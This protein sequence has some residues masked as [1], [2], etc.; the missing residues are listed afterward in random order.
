MIAAAG[1][2]G[3]VGIKVSPGMNF[4]DIQHDDPVPTYV[5]LAKAIAPLGL[6]YLHVMRAGI[7]AEAAL[8][9][10]FP[11]V[12]APKPRGE[13]VDWDMDGCAGPSHLWTGALVDAR[14]EDSLK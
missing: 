5:A 9:D 3:K 7:G 1:S 10:A 8:R 14:P 2:P 13:G 4:N 6:A 11:G 12:L